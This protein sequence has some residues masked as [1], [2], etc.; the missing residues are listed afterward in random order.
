[1]TV[2]LF[3]LRLG[4][5]VELRTSATHVK[6]GKL[7]WLPAV[8]LS[9]NFYRC[10]VEIAIDAGVRTVSTLESDSAFNVPRLRERRL[11]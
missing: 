4:R 7:V 1:M 6:T 3:E 8:V 10:E 11:R 5:E 9:R 2:N